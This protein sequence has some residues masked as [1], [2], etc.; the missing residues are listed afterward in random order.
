[1]A[2]KGYLMLGV[3]EDR[4]HH[5]VAL[6]VD[7]CSSSHCH[8]KRRNSHIREERGVSYSSSM[9]SNANMF[10]VSERSDKLSLCM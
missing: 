8:E 5:D 7:Y 10:V 9:S 1:M 6:E 3:R 2:V 4:E